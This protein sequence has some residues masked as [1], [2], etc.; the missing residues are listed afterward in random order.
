[1][2]SN[3][4]D[5]RQGLGVFS[6]PVSVAVVG[7]SDNPAKWGYWLARGALGG[8]HRRPVDLV[9]H[10]GSAVLGRPSATSLS[11]LPRVPDLVTLAVP[12]A[13]IGAVVDEGLALGVRGFLSITARIPGE[14][15]L[16]QRIRAGGARLIGGNSLGIYDADSELSLAWGHFFPG[17]VAIVTQSGQLG[18]ELA[19]RLRREGIGVSRFVSVGNQSDVSA[20]EVLAELATHDSTEVIALY[21]EGFS[22]GVEL[23]ETLR[24]L[25]AS[26]KPTLLL[27]VG[28]S[29]ASSRLARSHTGSMTADTDLVDAVCRASGVLRVRTPA[30]LVDVARGFLTVRGTAGRAIGIA[31]DSGGQCGIAADVATDGGLLVAP[32]SDLTESRLAATV[33]DDAAR[34]NP[35]DLAGSG[36]ADLQVYARVIED[37]LDDPGVETVVLTGYFGLYSEDTPSLAEAELQV[38]HRIGAAAQDRGKAVVVHTM[39]PDS[40][41]A[42]ALRTA[43]VPVVGSIERAIR[44]VRGLA[45]LHVPAPGMTQQGPAVQNP[46]EPGYWPAR[47]LL[48][49]AGVA[50]PPARHI[51]DAEDLTEIAA[52]LTSPYVLKAGWIEHKTEQD[53]VVLGLHDEADLRASYAEMHSRLGDGEYVV[54]EQDTRSHCVEMIVGARRDSALGPVVVVGMGGTEAEVWKDVAIECAPVDATRALT[55]LQRLRCAPLLRAFR[56]RPAVDTAA[57]AEVVAAISQLISTREDLTEVELNPVRVSPQG[58]LAVDALV[59]RCLPWGAPEYPDRASTGHAEPSADPNELTESTSSPALP[60]HQPEDALQ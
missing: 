21:L 47:A 32:L 29:S 14:P 25:R 22:S 3:L 2:T 55:M 16:A 33:P 58:A 24:L 54:E 26:G 56:G 34:E 12:A 1:M 15:D 17:P 37:L 60:E 10:T 44:I 52:A 30:E 6:D 41:V 43:G 49:S 59:V 51:G 46:A 48:R 45:A 38:A 4:P 23:F 36:E 5:A 7:A 39:A 50:L 18:S 8:A 31:G 40:L 27:T 19:I 57:L 20:T 53:A 28:A 42:T 11:D 35:V 13:S 9:N